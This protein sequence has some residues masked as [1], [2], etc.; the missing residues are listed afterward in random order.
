MYT[1][2]LRNVIATD[3]PSCWTWFN[4]IISS[5]NSRTPM[6]RKAMWKYLFIAPRDTKLRKQVWCTH[7]CVHMLSCTCTSAQTQL[8]TRACVHM[9]SCRARVY[10]CINMCTHACV[11]MHVH[12]HVH[13]HA[14]TS[15]CIH[16]H[17]HVHIHVYMHTCTHAC[18]RRE[19]VCELIVQGN[20]RE[21]LWTLYAT[22]V[23]EHRNG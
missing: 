13:T 9:R 16:V 11:H 23:R 14:C 1:T 5:R 3:G 21:L 18:T 20:F 10:T 15:T 17:M 2:T 6:W 8:C 4:L 22:H 19:S 7:V 12:I